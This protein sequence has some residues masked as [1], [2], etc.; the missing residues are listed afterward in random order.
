[1]P[2][3]VMRRKASDN[4]YLHKDFHASM[5]CGIDYLHQNYGEEAVREY[6][7]EFTKAFYAPLTEDIKKRGL[8]AL[9]EH[10]DKIYKIEGGKVD[11]SYDDDK[12]VIKVYECP[13]VMHM[14]E[15]NR[16]VAQLFY[17]TT[18][19]VNEALVEGTPYAAEFED[20]DEQTGGNIQR[21]YRRD[22][23]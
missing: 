7:R 16:L 3:E 4:E 21:F 1:M 15:N 22:T 2:K 8:I 14:R 19:T 20:Y 23:K 5:S 6:L 18:R 9:K 10:F 17:E 11:I 12:L 13:A